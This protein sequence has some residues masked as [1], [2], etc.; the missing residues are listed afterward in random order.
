MGSIATLDIAFPRLKE[1]LTEE[2]GLLALLLRVVAGLPRILAGRSLSATRA[3]AG[4]PLTA[5][6]P[7]ATTPLVFLLLTP[8]AS[9]YAPSFLSHGLLC[10]DRLTPPAA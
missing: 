9:S 1:A 8:L 5:L 6:G 7:C 2:R 10:H 4:L 3:T